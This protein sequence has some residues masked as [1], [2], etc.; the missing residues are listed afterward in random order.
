MSLYSETVIDVHRWYF[1]T[2]SGTE[3]CVL[4]KLVYVHTPCS[5][6]VQRGEQ[7]ES[8]P[9]G[10]PRL[11]ELMFANEIVSSIATSVSKTSC[12]TFHPEPSFNPN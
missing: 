8:A 9:R 4:R 12:V 6:S 5:F 10:M 3:T 11:A 1:K 7:T 2:L